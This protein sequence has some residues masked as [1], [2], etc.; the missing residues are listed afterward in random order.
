MGRTL[1][2]IS[3]VGVTRKLPSCLPEPFLTSSPSLLP[4]LKV[5]SPDQLEKG[6]GAWWG[7]RERCQCRDPTPALLWGWVQRASRGILMPSV[8]KPHPSH[9]S[10]FS[11][12]LG[13][14]CNQKAISWL[15]R[16]SSVLFVLPIGHPALKFINSIQ[17]TFSY[18]L[19]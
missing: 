4:P 16:P 15:H 9:I 10:V 6:Q 8:W 1:S 2:Q 3:G 12:R 19:F 17:P 14:L 18:F 11:S 5:C 13:Q 7:Q